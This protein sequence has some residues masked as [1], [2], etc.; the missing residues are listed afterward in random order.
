MRGLPLGALKRAR[1]RPTPTW[2]MCATCC[3]S[4]AASSTST[5]DAWPPTGQTCRCRQTPAGP[6][7]SPGRARLSTSP[8]ICWS[9]RLPVLV[10]NVEVVVLACRARRFQPGPNMLRH[11]RIV[12]RAIRA[13][14]EPQAQEMGVWAVCA[15]HK[16]A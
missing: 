8:W 14:R 1:G 2:P 6:S 16:R 5:A 3:C 15:L 10:P 11:P 13:A 12:I 7:I 9:A 4:R